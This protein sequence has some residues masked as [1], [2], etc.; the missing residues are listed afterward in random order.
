MNYLSHSRGG[1]TARYRRLGYRALL[2]LLALASPL[3]Q[4][5]EF[6]FRHDNVLGT[7]MEI[8]VTALTIEDAQAAESKA[9]AEIDR[10]NA[11][12][13]TYDPQSIISKFSRAPKN[14]PQFV[15]T[16][17]LELL[18]ASDW[19]KIKTAGAFNPLIKECS[20]L[21]KES[22]ASNTVPNPDSIQQ[23]AER[24]SKPAWTI[25][26]TFESVTR[27]E[28][29]A[30]SLNAIAKGFIIDRACEEARNAS[31]GIDSVLLSIGGDLKVSGSIPQPVGVTDPANP[32]DN[33]PPLVT[34]EL[35]NHAVT[36]SANYERGFTIQGRTYSHIIDPRN[37][38]PV[39]SG[40]R[41]ASVISKNANQADAL[42][43]TL[44]V[45][46]PDEG[47]ALIESLPDT[48]CLIVCDNS[49][50]K[51][52]SGFDAYVFKDTSLIPYHTTLT[53]DFELQVDFE[54][55][56][57]DAR[58]YERPYVAIWIEDS[59]GRLVKTL[60][61]WA[62][63]DTNYVKK[64]SRWIRLKDKNWG[65]INALS[66]ATRKPGKYSLVWDGTN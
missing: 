55:N 40:A 43:T 25:D 63:I 13:S 20:T 3:M 35:T 51:R 56:H 1:F 18:V 53:E 14:T 21:W 28:D 32:A 22:A 47:I 50:L 11:I 23:A 48:E 52:S 58:R 65:V 2:A 15:P 41:S 31:T 4:S 62:Q 64:L 19:W 12:F 59:D 6:V 33:A 29:I 61:L 66:R 36:T 27:I 60:C 26:P 37:G 44:M 24:A 16:E 57:P 9:L 54:I 38:Y 30:I 8:H 49:E 17:F 42:S 34:L 5:A 10:L 46:S 7:S 45:L 39:S